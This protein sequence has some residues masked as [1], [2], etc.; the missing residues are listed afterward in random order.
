ML[1]AV[2]PGYRRLPHTYDRAADVNYRM[3]QLLQLGLR[4]PLWAPALNVANRTGRPSLDYELARQKANGRP[5]PT[6]NMRRR[7]RQ[8]VF[9]PP[10][11]VARPETAN[12]PNPATVGTWRGLA[13]PQSDRLLRGALGVQS[14]ERAC[15]NKNCRGPDIVSN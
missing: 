7:R 8:S 2:K 1:P 6:R 12:E 15:C 9:L 10:P 13:R 5:T 3:L 4:G 11:S 14:S